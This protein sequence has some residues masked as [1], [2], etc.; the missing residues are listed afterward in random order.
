MS[1]LDPGEVRPQF[2]AGDLNN[3]VIAAGAA[4]FIDTDF[5]AHI[6]ENATAVNLYVYVSAGT[7]TGARAPGETVDCHVP[8]VNTVLLAGVVSQHVELYR[9][10]GGN[11]TYVLMGYWT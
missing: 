5:S 11:D 10:L 9:Q 6:P 3:F 7:D 1:N 4:G 2:H 8:F